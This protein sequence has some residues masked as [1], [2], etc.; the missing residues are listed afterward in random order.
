MA[1]AAKT[2][3]PLDNLFEYESFLTIL[4][5]YVDLN[6]FVIPTDSRDGSKD[7]RAVNYHQRPNSLY[8]F[9]KKYNYKFNWDRLT[10]P[11]FEHKHKKDQ[12]LLLD[13][14]FFYD[15]FTP[16][17]LQGKRLGTVFSGAFPSSEVNYSQ[18]RSS[19]KQLTG[20]TASPES[21]E[22]RQFA[23][24]MLETPVVEGSTLLAYREALE[25]FAS[26][27]A[28]GKNFQASQRLQELLTQV[29]SKQFPHSYWMDWALGL[30]TRQATPHWGMSVEKMR[31]VQTDIGVSRVPTTV[32]TVIPLNTFGKRR[33]AVEEMIR[34]YRFQRRSFQFART[35]P[36]TV[37]GKLEHYGSVFVTSADAS[38][39][40]PERRREIME[41]ADRIHSFAVRELGGPALMGI[42]ETVA[43]GEIL[44]E[45]YRQAVLAL[46]L[47]RESGKEIVSFIPSRVEKPEGVLEIMGLLRELKGKIETAS[48]SGLEAIL[49]SYLKQVLTISLN[50]P[51]QIRWHL[52]YGL[53]QM[54][55]GI[56]N[57]P[58][59]SEKSG[60]ELH[61]NL[62]LALGKAGTTQEMVLAFKDGLEKLLYLMQGANTLQDSY[63]IEKV[64]N[65]VADHFRETLPV[66]R[67]AKLAGTSVS[68]LSRRF[69]KATGVGLEKYL[70]N[71]RL[72]EAKQLLK[73]GN[74]SVAQ[75]AK[76]CGFKPGS[77]FARFFRK[78][79]G[80]S[81]QQF[82]NKTRRT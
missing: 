41:M 10:D 25:L 14:L 28:Y 68:T 55:D 30:P 62:V 57:Q 75:I 53:I 48:S 5:Y 26:V 21:G 45:S 67:L 61:E 80:V 47:G 64:R 43:P 19:W 7:W 59:F 24:V 63:S 79:T 17:R 56:E 2:S 20:Q 11:A 73:T 6:C 46:H 71:L 9:Q 77:H 29:F 37:G 78:K 1:R 69:Q 34:I 38:K 50:D 22:F 35:I 13:S 36:Q 58:N 27:L 82:R 42:G 44:S 81:P 18:L 15:I 72:E 12:P 23:R 3:K 39:S 16:I 70:Q 40:R 52:Q 33:D 76:A 49:D 74:L 31:W 32:I 65:Y 66:S 4:R 51:E 54:R 60:I 8:D